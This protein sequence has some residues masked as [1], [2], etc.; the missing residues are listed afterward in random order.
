[1]TIIDAMQSFLSFLSTNKD[2]FIAAG[3]LVGAMTAV[4]TSWW[5][6]RASHRSMVSQMRERWIEALRSE[7][8]ELKGMSLFLARKSADP[9]FNA[10]E[11]LHRMQILGNKIILRLNPNN[12]AHAAL[13]TAVIRFGMAEDEEERDL[14]GNEL[15]YHAR[16]VIEQTWQKAERG[17]L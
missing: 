7:I 17:K 16:I 10:P 12:D 5:A 9:N 1:M 8:A 14:V 2:A 3:V 11:F 4:G 15:V 6:S 13:E